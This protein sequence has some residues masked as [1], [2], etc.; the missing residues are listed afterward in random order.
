MLGE[1][2]MMEEE[3]HTWDVLNAEGS[4]VGLEPHVGD[5]MR[6]FKDEKGG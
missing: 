4:G 2:V 3:V 1:V 6:G 5:G